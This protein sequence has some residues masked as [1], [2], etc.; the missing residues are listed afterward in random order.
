M[1]G[2]R[3]VGVCALVLGIAACTRVFD[4]VVPVGGGMVCAPQSTE[5]G[6]E[7]TPWPTTGHTMNSDPW[8]V[9]HNQVITVMKPNVLVLNFD[10]G[11]SGTQTMTYAKQVANVLAAGSAYHAYSNPAAPDFL[12]YNILP[13]VDLTSS[14]TG[15]SV[16]GNV[17]LTSTGDFDPSALFNN[18]KYNH[19]YGYPDASAPG[20]YQSLC[21]LFENGTINEVWIQDGGGT[22]LSD[23]TM[24]PRAPLYAERK[25]TYDGNGVA[26]G[27][28]DQCIGGGSSGTQ[29]CLNI[30]CT[31]TVRL[32]HLDPSPAGGPGCDVQVR[33]WGIEGMWAAL[34]G[35]V[36]GDANAF[37]N[38]NFRSQFGVTFNS[39][40]EICASSPCVDY[41]NPM[42]ARSTSGDATTFDIDP[43][44]QGCGSSLFPPNATAPD[45][46]EDATQVNARCE[47]FGL[48]DG[49]DGMDQYQPY[50]NAVV[51]NYD[52]MYTGNSQCPAGWQVYWRQSMP[53]YQNQAIAGDG[54]PMKNWWPMLFY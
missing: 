27:T 51:A 6:C 21:Q 30:A 25:M 39:W 28:F 29:T 11:Q 22:Q 38:Q 53:G 43:F 45:D 1:R 16:N 33:G 19:F 52:Q 3:A 26:T 41:P 20:G 35:D 9:T 7:P 36:A 44:S 40:S 32:A 48:H 13:I 54:T 8:L 17:P 4:A 15:P 18:A 5:P 50:S 42:R 10:N 34:P 23:G 49:S 12:E 37:L 47:H 46:F 14:P 31:V 2:A 24:L